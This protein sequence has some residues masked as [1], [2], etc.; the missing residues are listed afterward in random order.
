MEH[1]CCYAGCSRI[2]QSARA[3]MCPSLNPST[4]PRRPVPARLA[5]PAVPG[6]QAVQRAVVRASPA[7]QADRHMRHTGFTCS[8]APPGACPIRYSGHPDSGLRTPRN[9]A[10]HD[11]GRFVANAVIN[12]PRSPGRGPEQATWVTLATSAPSAPRRQ[13]PAAALRPQGSTGRVI[14]PGNRNNPRTARTTTSME[15]PSA[16]QAGVRRARRLA[17]GSAALAIRRRGPRSAA[18]TA[19]RADRPAPGS[20]PRRRSPR[21]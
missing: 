13:A 21:A 8:A 14:S 6:G 17:G 5:R 10:F 2:S 20:R 12:Q 3:G 1:R 4:R 16:A 15:L 19:P 18:A 7:A 9:P 11:R